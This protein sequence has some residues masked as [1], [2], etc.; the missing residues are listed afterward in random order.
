MKDAYQLN[1]PSIAPVIRLNL[2]FFFCPPRPPSVWEPPEEI[3]RKASPRRIRVISLNVR[4]E[5]NVIFFCF[6]EGPHSL[7][8]ERTL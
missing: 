4:L 7:I 6:E 3:K 2:I 5:R 8:R 1:P